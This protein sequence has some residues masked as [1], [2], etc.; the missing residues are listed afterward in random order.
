MTNRRIETILDLPYH[1]HSLLSYPPNGP[2]PDHIAAAELQQGWRAGHARARIRPVRR[3]E[4]ASLLYEKSDKQMA[5]VYER[6]HEYLGRKIVASVNKDEQGQ[7]A[8]SV[9]CHHPDGRE[10]VVV[11]SGGFLF[12]HPTYKHL[13]DAQRAADEEISQMGHLCSDLC[14]HWPQLIH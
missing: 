12:A 14:E 9:R 4:L 7:W 3:R 5:T 1:L 2:L 10:L 13:A 6:T 8:I 11:K